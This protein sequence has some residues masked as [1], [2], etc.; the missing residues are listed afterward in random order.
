MYH[1]PPP[2]VLE[3]MIRTKGVKT[4]QVNQSEACRSLMT[5]ESLTWESN[6]YRAAELLN[7]KMLMFRIMR[8]AS[9]LKT[10][11]KKKSFQILL[12]LLHVNFPKGFSF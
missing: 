12:I 9:K 3:Q 10:P 1:F 4:P 8:E 7:I 5:V 6:S 2:L 11:N